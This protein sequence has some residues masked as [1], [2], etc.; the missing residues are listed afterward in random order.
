MAGVVHRSNLSSL[1]SY[2]DQIQSVGAASMLRQI[3]L[4]NQRQHFLYLCCHVTLSL[5]LRWCDVCNSSSVV[6]KG[7]CFASFCNQLHLDSDCSL[8]RFIYIY[9]YVVEATSNDGWAR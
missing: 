3:I 6:G 2:I 7:A 8:F 5:S 1:C 4:Q 9:V